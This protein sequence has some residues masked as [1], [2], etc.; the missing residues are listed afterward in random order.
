MI[1]EG[2]PINVNCLNCK[3]GQC[4]SDADARYVSALVFGN[5][6][7]GSRPAPNDLVN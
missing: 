5:P 6:S 1:V 2:V 7:T 3:I 4:S